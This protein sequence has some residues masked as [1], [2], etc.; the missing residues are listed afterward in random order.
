MRM[1][2]PRRVGA[3]AFIRSEPKALY[4]YALFPA[5]ISLLPYARTRLSRPRPGCHAIPGAQRAR[6]RQRAPAARQALES[7]AH[8]SA[9]Q[10][11]RRS[12]LGRLAGSLP[13]R[14]GAR[15]PGE[16]GAPGAGP[17]TH[18]ALPADANSAATQ[19]GRR[20]VQVRLPGA[21]RCPRRCHHRPNL[22]ARRI[23]LAARSAGGRRAL[24]HAA[25]RRQRAADLS[26]HRSVEGPRQRQRRNRLH[27]SPHGPGYRRGRPRLTGL[28]R[29]GH[30]SWPAHGVPDLPPRDTCPGAGLVGIRHR[31]PLHCPAGRAAI[32]RPHPERPRTACYRAAVLVLPD[33]GAHASPSTGVC[34]F[35][36][37]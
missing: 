35:P 13:C 4:G 30:P 26:G 37:W 1:R 36:C 31:V 9:P 15:S 22:A 24:A 34:C 20:R 19:P 27:L 23:R 6:R 14:R 7:A 3:H 8:A 21:P 16:P 10:A 29:R 25:W 28:R 32:S 17:A 12:L 5:I 2:I 18:G 11:A 33:A